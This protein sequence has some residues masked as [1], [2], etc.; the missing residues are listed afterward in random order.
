ML[1]RPLQAL[2]RRLEDQPDCLD[3]WIELARLVARV[4]GLPA[5][6][7]RDRDLPRLCRAWLQR[8]DEPAVLEIVLRLLDWELVEDEPAAWWDENA[9]LERREGRPYDLASGLPLT[10]RRRRD[11]ATVALIPE[12]P[13]WCGPPRHARRVRLDPFYLDQVPVTVAAYAR[14]LEATGH[15][16]PDPWEPQRAHPGRPVVF[17]TAADAEAYAA[18]VGG[19]L[20]GADER[21]HAAR[22]PER[23]AHYPWGRDAGSYLLPESAEANTNPYVG[24]WDEPES[25]PFAP[26]YA[27]DQGYAARPARDW[28]RYLEPVACRAANCSPYGIRDLAGNVFEWCQESD[29]AGM[30]MAQGGS[31]RHG[32]SQALVYHRAA[33][34]GTA[35]LGTVGFRVAHRLFGP[36]PSLSPPPPRAE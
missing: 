1:D 3:A 34:P 35:R 20:P 14:F 33:F 24:E 12:G 13:F 22:G 21:E 26:E 23:D 10:A 18:W 16:P 7:D 25:N 30:R 36:Q 11:G 19:D 28:S 6:L 2:A 32:L 17:V 27:E 4:E 5:F 8:P 29:D 9:R 15:A 31:W